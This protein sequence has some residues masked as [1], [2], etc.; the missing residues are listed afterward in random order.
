MGLPRPGGDTDSGFMWAEGTLWVGQH[1]N[2]RIHQ[3]EPNCFGEPRDIPA[4]EE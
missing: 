1:Q 4:F 2:G 3:I